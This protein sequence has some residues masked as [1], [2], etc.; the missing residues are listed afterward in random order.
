MM[1][2]EKSWQFLLNVL[3]IFLLGAE[4]VFKRSFKNA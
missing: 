4:T 3:I 2:N 1:E